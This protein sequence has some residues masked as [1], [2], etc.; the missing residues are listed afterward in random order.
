[1]KVVFMHSQNNEFRKGWG[2]K[3]DDVIHKLLSEGNTSVAP[4]QSR[5]KGN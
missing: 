3:R 4:C 5:Q 2:K 1:M